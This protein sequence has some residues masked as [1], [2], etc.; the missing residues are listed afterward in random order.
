[1][2][3]RPWAPNYPNEQQSRWQCAKLYTSST[4][5]NA[6]LYNDVCER[7]T[8]YICIRDMCEYN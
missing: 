8:G 1:M 3:C 7:Q 4:I 2:F 6:M 5:R